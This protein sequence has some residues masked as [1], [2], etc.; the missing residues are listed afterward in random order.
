MMSKVNPRLEVSILMPCLNEAE[1]LVACIQEAQNVLITNQ[2]KGEVLV[3]D[4]GST[5]GSIALAEQAGARIVRVEARGYGNAIMGG[6]EAATGEYVLVGDADGS[7]SFNELPAFLAALRDGDDLVMGCRMPSYGGTIMP[8]AMP[9]LHRWLGNP[10]LTKIGQLFFKVPIHDFHCGLRAFRRESVL[11]L[12]LCTTGMEFASEMVVKAALHC[13]KISEV[14]VTLKPDGRSRRPHLRTWRDGWR[15]LRFLLLY[16]PKWLLLYPGLSLSILGLLGFL[17][18]LPGTLYIGNIAFDTNTLLVS[19]LCLIV[20]FQIIVSYI[21]AKA[22]AIRVGLL[23]ADLKIKKIIASN[24]VETGIIAGLV[25]LMV[26]FG[27]LTYALTTWQAAS[28]GEIS[29][30]KSLRIVV[31][32]VT[33]IALGTQAI[34][35]GFILAILNIK[36]R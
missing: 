36:H 26:G 22:Y 27:L 23:P 12:N 24:P 6:I 1:T 5:D 8:G 10:V 11:A 17:V 21:F 35:S 4:N 18:L 33:A 3:A 31:P 29:Y 25:L 13:L 32:A 34:F 14:A 20:G 7:Y 9:W 2:I 19:S 15:H 28:F 16:S 30:P